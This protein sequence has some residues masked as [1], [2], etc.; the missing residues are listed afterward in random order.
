MENSQLI[1][2][3]SS[4]SKPQAFKRIVTL[5]GAISALVILVVS[6]SSSSSI[7]WFP[8]LPHT[9][10]HCPLSGPPNDGPL[11][12]ENR[13]RYQSIFND[14]FNNNRSNTAADDEAAPIIVALPTSSRSGR[15]ESDMEV[16][17]WRTSSNILY[18]LGGGFSISDAVVVV[19]ERSSEMEIALFLPN[20][21]E[22]EAIFLGGF[23]S[24]EVLRAEFG[25]HS[26]HPMADFASFVQQRRGGRGNGNDKARVLTTSKEEL[27]RAVVGQDILD[28]VEES[29][30]LQQVFIQARF[31]KSERELARLAYASSVSAWAH[32]VIERN[33]KKGRHVNELTLASLF[34]HLCTL[35]GA[36]LQAYPPIVGAGPHAAV[37]HYRTGEN[38]TAGYAPIDRG[39]LVLIDA[40]GEYDGYASDLTR[41]W[42]RGGKWTRKTR[43]LHAAVMKAQKAAID[44]FAEG[45][46]TSAVVDAAYRSLLK[47]LIKMEFYVKGHS[48]DELLEAGALYVFMPHGLGHP[49]GL[50]VHDPVPAKYEL[51]QTVAAAIPPF[52]VQTAPP[53]NFKIYRG[54]AAT[55]EP[56]L[57][58][59]PGLLEQLKRDSESN[60]GGLGRFVN[61][62]VVDGWTHVGGVR[63]ED[64]LVIDHHGKKRIIT[65]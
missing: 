59:I 57:Y 14:A 21:T 30:E 28:V 6:S 26:V 15:L 62:D 51:S 4:S 49:V 38:V 40:A 36:R 20:Q 13:A 32:D 33:V 45:V 16:A 61:W 9:P 31:V 5:L 39:T 10:T 35:C 18:L 44:T 17:G 7:G 41:T 60:N 53:T 58:I 34:S 55:L 24:P 64:V 46:D 56:G 42:A 63:N 25:I 37:L 54:Y 19:L 29:A 23:P 65:R 43:A 22:R 12:P 47:S 1:K 48:V 11:Y 52:V 50:D 3:T 27:S 8:R 2:R